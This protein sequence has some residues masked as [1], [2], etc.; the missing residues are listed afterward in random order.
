MK[1]FIFIIL[2]AVIISPKYSNAQ[3]NNAA[4][5]ATAVG[6]LMA[7]GAAIAT[8]ENMKE[9]AELVATEFILKNNPELQNFSLKTLDFDGKKLKDMSSVSVISYKIQEF[10]PS[11]NPKLNGKKQVLFGFTS[12]G[13]ITEQGIDFSRVTWI[14]I[15]KEEWMNMMTAYAKVSSSQKNESVIRQNILNGIIVNKGVKVKGDLVIPFYKLEGDM[16]LT[17]DYSPLMKFIYNERSLGIFF[18]NTSDLVQIG[19]DD[20]IR[21][22][23]FFMDK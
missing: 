20:L 2:A 12:Y 18:K 13:W 8:I 10:I 16:Y 21:I 23:D 17:M 9:R 11:D 6:G 5:I 14:L 7:I 3:N 4:G 15:D 19:R 1:K 22:H